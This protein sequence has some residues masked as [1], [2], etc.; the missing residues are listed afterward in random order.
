MRRWLIG[1]GRRSISH[2]RWHVG[3]KMV[4]IR[5]QPL[6]IVE[7]RTTRIKLINRR[8]VNISGLLCT[9]IWMLVKM[10][11]LAWVLHRKT[12]G[13]KLTVR[14]S[15]HIITHRSRCHERETLRSKSH[16]RQGARNMRRDHG[17]KLSPTRRKDRIR[18]TLMLITVEGADMGLSIK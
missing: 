10:A 7:E 4:P 17:S 16:T 15:R 14:S 9:H 13:R 18:N 6:S 2:L 1:H 3:V 11:I 5:N 8:E 12:R